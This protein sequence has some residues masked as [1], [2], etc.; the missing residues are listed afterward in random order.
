MHR[1]LQERDIAITGMAALFPGAN[2]LSE[3]WRNIVNG[4][5]ATGPVPVE[6][7]LRGATDLNDSL[8]ELPRCK[9][10]GFVSA[11]HIDPLAFGIAPNDL[12]YIE[13]DQLIALKLATDALTDAGLPHLSTASDRIGIILGRGAYFTPGIGRYEQKVRGSQQWMHAIR[14]WAPNLPID[15]VKRMGEAFV[16]GLGYEAKGSVIG[17]VPNLA[18]SRIANRLNLHGPAYTLDAACASSLLAIDQSIRLLRDNSCDVVIAGGIHHCHD[19]AFWKVFE[20]LGALS[21]GQCIRPF[22]AHADGLLIGE[23]AGIVVLKRVDDA[24]RDGDRI[25]AIIKG[26]GVSSDGRG[27]S[28]M[29][30]QANGQ[31]RAIRSAWADAGWDPASQDSVDFI[32]AHGTATPAGDEAELKT[33]ATIFGPPENSRA[34]LGSVK[35][36]IGHT[37]PAAGIASVIKTALALHYGILPPSLNCRTPNKLLSETRFRIL[38]K[39]EPWIAHGDRQHRRAGV[40][41]FGFGGINAHLVMQSCSSICAQSPSASVAPETTHLE[42]AIFQTSSKENLESALR[43]WLAGDAQSHV[44]VGH[45]RLAVLGPTAERIRHALTVV[46]E[47]RACR[48]QQ[49]VWYSPVPLVE[50]GVQ[51]KTAFVFPGL[52]AHL[53][54][55]ASEVAEHFRLNAPDIRNVESSDVLAHAR[56]VLDAG[57]LF[58]SA[59]HRLGVHADAMAGHSIGELAAFSAGGGIPDLG[60]ARLR[61]CTHSFTFPPFPYVVVSMSANAVRGMLKDGAWGNM[62]ISHENASQ[63]TIVCGTKDMVERFVLEVRSRGH[64]AQVLPFLSGLHTPMFEPYATSF[65]EGVGGSQVQ[66]PRCPVWSATTAAPYPTRPDDIR[67][68]MRRHLIEPVRFSKMIRAMYDSGFRAFVQIGT[69]QLTTLIDDTLR[70]LPHVTTSTASHRFGGMKQLQRLLLDLWSSGAQVNPSVLGDQ[71]KTTRHAICLDL[72]SGLINP[73]SKAQP[74]LEFTMNA[75][76]GNDKQPAALPAS[77]KAFAHMLDRAKSDLAQVVEASK[78]RMLHRDIAPQPIIHVSLDAMP[79]LR[80]HSLVRQS[81]A[82]TDE[83]ERR[84]IVPGTMLIQWMWQHAAAT[85]KTGKVVAIED[86]Q[87]KRWVEA[88]PSIN[89]AVEVQSSSADKITVRMGGYCQATFVFAASYTVGPL[90]PQLARHDPCDIAASAIYDERWMFHGPAFRGIE[91]LV[92]CGPDHVL[93]MIR[94]LPLPGA[95]LDNMGQ[96]VGFLSMLRLEDRSLAFPHS[97]ARINIHSEG[98]PSGTLIECLVHSLTSDRRSVHAD[99]HASVGAKP[100][101][102]IQQ[103][104][105]HRFSL[106]SKLQSSTYFPERHP[107]GTMSDHGW[108]YVSESWTDAASREL[109][110]HY[111]LAKMERD[112]YVTLNTHRQRQWLLGRIA[113]KD[114]VRNLLWKGGKRDI[115]PAEVVIS[116]DENGAPFAQGNHGL[117]LP[118]MHISIAHVDGFAVALCRTRKSAPGGVGIDTERLRPVEHGLMVSCLTPEEIDVIQRLAKN[119]ADLDVL[120]WRFWTAKEAVS[121]LDGLGLRHKPRDIVITSV[122]SI[123]LGVSRYRSKETE[124]RHTVLHCRHRPNES[125]DREFIVSWTIDTEDHSAETRTKPP[126]ARSPGNHAHP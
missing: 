121:K 38:E 41:A 98:P 59:L 100:W 40:N 64:F 104:T 123:S 72:G 63:Q 88:I 111:Q 54:D 97:I 21:E 49:N 87:F 108:S 10:G 95:T 23:G 1:P 2:N 5:D 80:D 25:Y 92:H 56:V 44:A 93:G 17:L 76:A 115:Y 36:M 53:P 84:P 90:Q 45:V 81:T 99:I 27:A 68:L 109:L 51:L 83:L 113:A 79:F 94:A 85:H 26:S 19:L 52:D 42:I 11:V 96:L 67:S 55:T 78:R 82:C 28:L 101:L 122:D 107:V 73:T 75:S 9:R 58:N 29:S 126:M 8:L 31:I 32:E 120:F 16:S 61:Y 34:V 117:Q 69:G 74:A 114:A 48:G 47:E 57:L 43:H 39:H 22:D 6:R 119:S 14:A 89:I 24:L 46:T 12:E 70:G 112:R 50:E 86:I 30:P 4:V 65:I 66:T 7:W 77:T 125:V 118:P 71:G 33:L 35:S 18:A 105:D 3:Y 13:P 91:R 116:N 60:E 15:A 103:W 20:A 37:M 106:N 102:T 124:T 110:S 62:V